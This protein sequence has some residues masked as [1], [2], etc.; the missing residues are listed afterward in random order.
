VVVGESP[1]VFVFVGVTVLVGLT[2]FVGVTVTVKVGVTVFVGVGVGSPM[3]TIVCTSQGSSLCMTYE[4]CV[5]IIGF[6]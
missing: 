2:V 3:V 5:S 4:L 1:G 6:L